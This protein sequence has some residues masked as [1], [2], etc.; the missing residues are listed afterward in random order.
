MEK[1]KSDGGTENVEHDRISSLPDEVLTHILSFLSTKEAVSTCVLSKRWIHTWATVPVLDFNLYEFLSDNLDGHPLGERE[2]R[3]C[4]ARFEQFVHGVLNNH[5]S[6]NLD[7]VRYMRE[8]QRSETFIPMEWLDLVA[9]LMP[10]V[11]NIYIS[12]ADFKRG[13]YI[14]LPD[15]VFS[16]AKLQHL[17]MNIN[18]DKSPIVRPASIILPLLK[19]LQLSGVE[20]H[21]DFTQKLVKGCPAL[22]MLDLC[23][24]EL[25]FSSISSNALKKLTI[26]QCRLFENM[27]ISC[28]GLVSLNIRSHFQWGGVGISLKKAINLVNATIRLFYWHRFNG[29]GDDDVPVLDL[30]SSLSSATEL[31]LYFDTDLKEPVEEDVSNCR[32][33]K[34][35]K[36]LYIG[37][38]DTSYDFYLIACLLQCSPNL[39]ELNLLLNV[40]RDKIQELRQEVSGD[41][42]FCHEYLETVNIRVRNMF[43]LPSECVENL[44]KTLGKYIK[45]IGKIIITYDS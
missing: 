15:S 16:S 28:P 31:A 3:K 30:L 23:C 22:E 2:K 8:M 19:V 24:C 40:R 21:N 13:N 18:I 20:L 36:K 6:A 5:E 10:R 27:Q 38:W 11:I 29:G 25:Y 45:K 4:V 39:N 33:F 44:M 7:V 17:K 26:L 32:H 12:R 1:P 34:N 9:L 41:A 14:D 37:M 35:L 42:L 43:E